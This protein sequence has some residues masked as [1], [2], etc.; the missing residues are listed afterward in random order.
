MT[1]KGIRGVQ[2]SSNLQMIKGGTTSSYGGRLS[3]KIKG[4]EIDGGGCSHCGNKK[5]NIDTCFKVHGYPEWWNDMKAKKQKEVAGGSGRVALASTEPQ[6]SLI[7]QV[8]YDSKPTNA[9]HEQ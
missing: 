5:H 4:Q 9:Q 3:T 1:T 2:Q 8:E 6:L 7:S